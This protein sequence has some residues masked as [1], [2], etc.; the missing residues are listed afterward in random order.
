MAE[1]S[2]PVCPNGRYSIVRPPRVARWHRSPI[3]TPTSGSEMLGLPVLQPEGTQSESIDEQGGQR[4]RRFVE[5]ALD[6]ALGQPHLGEPLDHRRQ[7]G[8]GDVG[9]D[10]GIRQAALLHPAD[11]L[12]DLLAVT[13][14]ASR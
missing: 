14:A 9:I 5:V 4:L 2:R 3:P 11:R 13:G 8:G 12:A 7:G 6:L 10:G 1:T